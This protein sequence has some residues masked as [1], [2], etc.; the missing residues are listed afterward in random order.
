MHLR[1]I[2]ILALLSAAFL[3]TLP[4]N[5]RLLLSKRYGIPYDKL[6]LNKLDM[7]HRGFFQRRAKVASFLNYVEGMRAS[8]EGCWRQMVA[9]GAFEQAVCTAECICVEAPAV[10]SS[11]VAFR[12]APADEVVGFYFIRPEKAVVQG[13]PGV[14]VE[15]EDLHVDDLVRRATP[16][17]EVVVDLE[18]DITKADG[19]VQVGS[20]QPW[21]GCLQRAA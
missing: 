13:P 18:G 9:R 20:A 1:R 19:E 12:V 8:V 10:A 11:G 7:H 6:H 14:V 5:Q 2:Q 17:S 21:R 16:L 15:T 4:H 3:G